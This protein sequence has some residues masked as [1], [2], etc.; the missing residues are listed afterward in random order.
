MGMSVSARGLCLVET[1]F[2]GVTIVM[3]IHVQRRM[4]LKRLLMLLNRAGGRR[5]VCEGHTK[6][7]AL[8]ATAAQ[9]VQGRC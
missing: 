2:N 8:V 5:W 7:E 1:N 3:Q 4:D 6:K 9:H